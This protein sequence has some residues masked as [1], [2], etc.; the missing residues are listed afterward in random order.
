MSI[1][2]ADTPLLGSRPAD[3]NRLLR[4]LKF[5]WREVITPH[6]DLIT[7]AAILA[8]D[9]QALTEWLKHGVPTGSDTISTYALDLMPLPYQVP[10]AFKY[11]RDMQLSLQSRD[12]RLIAYSATRLAFVTAG[13]AFTALDLT[14]AT[15]QVEGDASEAYTIYDDSRWPSVFSTGTETSW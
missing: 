2:A 5:G 6:S 9:I 10:L 14:A 4:T 13:L 1:Q 8:L 7:N 12:W 15:F 11:G 3:E